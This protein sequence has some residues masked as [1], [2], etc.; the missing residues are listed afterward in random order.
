MT[1]EEVRG[2]KVLEVGSCDVNG[3][4][5]A[6]IEMLQP[7]EYIGIDIERGPGVDRVCRAE[8]LEKVFGNNVFDVVISTCVLEHVRYWKQ[9]LLNMKRV[10]KPGGI[11]IMIVPHTWAY[12]G[13]PS[14]YWRYSLEDIKH[15]FSD[16]DIMQL[17]EDSGMKRLVYV[18]AK[19]PDD[20]QEQRIEDYQLYS[21]ITGRR[22]R[23][24]VPHDFKKLRYR[25]LV[26]K[27]NLVI[28]LLKVGGKIFS[29]PN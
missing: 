1:L 14:D 23:E 29:R 28:F 25:L 19:K 27:S 22:E 11:I 20:F 10:C 6:V 24:L 15:I 8:D 4:V 12:H 5:R 2:K 3:S 7:A 9:A 17:D 21:V 16:F 13:H 18:K 26:L